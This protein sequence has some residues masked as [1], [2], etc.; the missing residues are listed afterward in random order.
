MTA[1]TETISKPGVSSWP[2][3]DLNLFIRDHVT[4]T[5]YLMLWLISLTLVTVLYA[6][7]QFN[8][9]PNSTIIVVIT[10][11][12]CVISVIVGELQHKHTKVSRWL[13]NHLF[14]SIT[15]SLLTLFI[16]LAL[17]AVL[18]GIWGYAVV[19]ATFDPALTAPEFRN[20]ETGASWGVL[21]GARK[22]LMTG[23]LDT[24]H[25]WR[26]WASLWFVVSLT[27]ISFFAYR[28]PL[29]NRLKALRYTMTAI[30]L[31][32]PLILFILLAGLDASGPFLS[33]QTLFIGEVMVLGIYG[34]LYWQ[35][36]VRFRWQSF[37]VWVFAWPVLYVVW[38]LIA[39]TDLFPVINVD[40]WGGFLFTMI[41]SVFTI[42]ASFPIG[43]ALA[44]GRRSEVRGIPA[45][46]TWPAAFAVTIWG[47]LS[48][49]PELLAA[50]RNNLEKLIAFWPLLILLLTYSFQRFF[51]GNVVAAASTIYI[52]VIRGVPLITV[53][54]MAIIMASLFFPA[55]IQIE[56][57]W[58]VLV[59][60][61]LFT[62]A[63]MA[64]NVRGGLQAIP[65]GQY[66]ASDALGLNTLQKMRFIIL[67]QALR[68]VIPAIVGLFI[69]VFKDSSLV[70]VVGLYELLGI[71]NPI[72]SN[73]QWLGLRTELYIFAAV[74]YFIGSFAMSSYSRRLE[75]QLG[76][77]V[78]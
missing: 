5:W 16:V 23:T 76:V 27:I 19:R 21:W 46:I 3:F 14:S 63:Y 51:N 10:W 29:R 24:E 45:W 1:Q 7:Q 17:L 26:V 34:L 39:R 9:A 78:R 67:P 66:E 12:I 30:W 71:T 41:I 60:F 74:V 50:A 56:N 69:G 55:G 65:K 49:T 8:A 47:F 70:A 75:T 36:V 43:V 54:F 6:R 40:K 22:L 18:R 35:R 15:N 32:S 25:L 73:P 42:I 33:I 59:A 48:S 28:P 62:A 72:I 44:L 4:A 52:E 2:A 13:H 64:E 37:A 61:S 58:A 68:A 53:L 31:L 20:P 57:V 77:G 11:M 38:R